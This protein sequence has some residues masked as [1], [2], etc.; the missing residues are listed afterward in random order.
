M[1]FDISPCLFYPKITLKRPHIQCVQSTRMCVFTLLVILG[2]RYTY[3]SCKALCQTHI[4]LVTVEQFV[5]L[6][7]ISQFICCPDTTQSK[8]VIVPL[9]IC[10][11]HFFV[12]K[13]I[14][15]ANAIISNLTKHFAVSPDTDYSCFMTRFKILR[16]IIGRLHET[17]AFG[18]ALGATHILKCQ[19]TC[20]LYINNRWQ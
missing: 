20:Q 4:T 17:T 2:I 8:H 15:G 10:I 16:E 11:S 13:R 9:I 1:H 19:L 14:G 18:A 5:P 12:N 6:C 3:C 7:N